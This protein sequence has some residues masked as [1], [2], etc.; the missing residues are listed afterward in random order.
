MAAALLE[1]ES[2][3]GPE[4]DQIIADNGGGANPDAPTPA[5]FAG[6]RPT[7]LPPES[8]PA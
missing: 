1:K 2:L 4:I 8:L 5:G 6:L 3:D 7:E